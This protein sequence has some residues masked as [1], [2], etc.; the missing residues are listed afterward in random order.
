VDRV[1]GFHVS[2]WNFA[3]RLSCAGARS[4]CME[5]HS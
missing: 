5:M 3:G 1:A 4:T 2:I